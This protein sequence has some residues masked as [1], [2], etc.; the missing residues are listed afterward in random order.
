M[1]KFILLF[2]ISILPLKALAFDIIKLDEL[3]VDYKHFKDGGRDPLFYDSKKKEYLGLN[4]N[5]DFAKIFYWDNIVHS[6]TDQYQFHLIGWNFKLGARVTKFLSLQ[7]EHHSQ[8]IL[9]AT[10]PY[11][12]YPVEDNVGIRLYLYGTAKRPA[13]IN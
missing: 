3:S 9:D 10:Y 13:L 7:M 5:T 11:M 4:I 6:A 2:V 1:K 12:A 8:H